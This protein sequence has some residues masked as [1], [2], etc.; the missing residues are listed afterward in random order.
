MNAPESLSEHE[1]TTNQA[2]EFDYAQD[3]GIA[4]FRPLGIELVLAKRI[5]RLW[6]RHH[7]H[8]DP[9]RHQHH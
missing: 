1:T 2:P 9:N 4:S 6:F 8:A 5:I 3:P 7:R